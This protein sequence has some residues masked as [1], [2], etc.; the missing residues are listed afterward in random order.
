MFERLRRTDAR[1]ARF[2]WR[3]CL[4]TAKL[5]ARRG[6]RPRAALRTVRA[7]DAAIAGFRPKNAAAARAFVK[8]QARIDRYRRGFDVAAHWTCYF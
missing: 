2:R 1:R 4:S 3:L 7:E 6:R 8:K 5:R